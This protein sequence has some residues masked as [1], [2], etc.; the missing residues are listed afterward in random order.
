M[1]HAMEILRKESPDDFRVLTRVPCTFSTI[2][3]ARKSPAYLITRKPIIQ[4]D[5]DDQVGW[6]IIPV[7][8]ID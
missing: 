6:W 5:Y 8:K 1:F 2:D 4:V 7:E 3:H